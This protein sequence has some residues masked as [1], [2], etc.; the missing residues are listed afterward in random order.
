[1]SWAMTDGEIASMWRTC[2][3]RNEQVN[4]LADLNVKSRVEML[5]KLREL[6]CDLRGVRTGSYGGGA[7]RKPPID[8][9][10]AMQLY[11]DGLDDLSISE[12]LGES[13]KRVAEWR[14]RMK[15][16]PN[17]VMKMKDAPAEEPKREEETME[18]VKKAETS[19][20]VGMSAGA[21][22]EILEGLCRGYDGGKAVIRC[23]GQEVRE[24]LVRVLYAGDGSVDSV[25]L[26]LG[27]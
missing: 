25:E 24:A 13:K 5:G 17:R 21:L 27:V 7:P 6:G 12:A 11:R 18:P 19:S 1:M 10:R 20:R 4:I 8:E 26:E 3:N 2:K 22:R 15:L 9:L 16:K 23:D 14:K